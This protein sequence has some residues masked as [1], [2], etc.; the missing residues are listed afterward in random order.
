MID[1]LVDKFVQRN[2]IYF[3]AGSSFKTT[4]PVPFIS[5]ITIYIPA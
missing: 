3:K 1:Y 4:F 5:K 2:R